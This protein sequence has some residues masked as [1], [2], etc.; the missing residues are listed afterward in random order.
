MKAFLALGLLLF[1]NL[2][3]AAMS[4]TAA[5]YSM[6][7][8]EVG[9]KSN[10]VTATGSTSDNQV[11]GFQ[12]GVSGV[13]NFSEKFG[14]KSGLF[15]VERPF[16]SDF[17]TSEV[18]GKVTYFEVPAFFMLKFEEYAGV[19]VG[20]SLGIK[21]GDELKPGSLTGIKAM[22]VPLTFGAQF[23]FL[24]N[25]GANV[26]FETIGGELATGVENSRAVGVNLMFALD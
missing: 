22:V 13:Y 3:F 8:A 15:Y 14:L 7:A 11:T 4:P 6:V 1:S 12:L 16:S 21:L 2:S 5:E 25:F 18:K 9:F 10:S 23:K 26:F 17:G 24:P 19:Y 20:P